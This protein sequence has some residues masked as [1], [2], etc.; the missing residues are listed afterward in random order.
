MEN[1]E[2]ERIYWH[3]VQ[4]C[5]RV[6]VDTGASLDTFLSDVYDSV[7]QLNSTDPVILDLLAIIDEFNQQ[8][9]VQRANEAA[10]EIFK[11]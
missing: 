10:S 4:D 11:A 6:L 2:I 8:L 3:T 9:E 1:D 5:A 7:R